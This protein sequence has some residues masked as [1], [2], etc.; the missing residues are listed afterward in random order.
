[1]VVSAQD[2]AAPA[3]SDTRP[4]VTMRIGGMTVG[5]RPAH[6]HPD[7]SVEI[8]GFASATKVEIETA[9]ATVTADEAEIRYGGVGQ[10]DELELRGNVRLKAKFAVEYR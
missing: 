5:M 9:S 10:L 2:A 7:G 3:V 8:R 6:T 1:M 4:T